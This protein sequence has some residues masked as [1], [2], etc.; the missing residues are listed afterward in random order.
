MLN[1]EFNYF[2]NK[3]VKKNCLILFIL[4]IIPVPFLVQI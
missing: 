1:R 4:P 2:E 3:N